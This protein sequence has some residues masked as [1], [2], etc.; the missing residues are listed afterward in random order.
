MCCGRKGNLNDFIILLSYLP[1][2]PKSA[3]SFMTLLESTIFWFHY[4][5]HLRTAMVNRK[6]CSSFCS[7]SPMVDQLEEVKTALED[8]KK[9]KSQILERR[10]TSSFVIILTLS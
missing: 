10:L 2:W 1:G 8:F 3:E 5:P 9:Q 6:D 7:T 4:D